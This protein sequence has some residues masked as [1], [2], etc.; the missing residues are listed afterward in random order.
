VVFIVPAVAGLI[1]PVGILTGFFHLIAIDSNIIDVA[2]ALLTFLIIMEVSCDLVAWMIANGRISSSLV[3]EDVAAGL[4]AISSDD[5]RWKEHIFA[6]LCALVFLDI[7]LLIITL[8][9]KSD[10]I[11]YTSVAVSLQHLLGMGAGK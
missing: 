2:L 4:S 11:I 3:A 7:L 9:N 10:F 1:I 5:V 8:F 6:Y